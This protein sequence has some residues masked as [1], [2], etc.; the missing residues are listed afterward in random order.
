MQHRKQI[1][2]TNKMD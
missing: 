1:E 2:G